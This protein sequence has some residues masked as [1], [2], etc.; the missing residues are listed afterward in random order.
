MYWKDVY[1]PFSVKVLSGQKI[2]CNMAT[3]FLSQ[4][5]MLS[6]IINRKNMEILF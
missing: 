3:L 4:K 2:P 5:L 6:H 1:E